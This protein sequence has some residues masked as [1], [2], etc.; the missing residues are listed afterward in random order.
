MKKLM[1]LS[2]CSMVLFSSCVAKKEFL[3]LEAKQQETQDLLNTA[4]VKLNSCLSDAAAANARVE[5]MKEQLSDMRRSNEA[6]I[7]NSQ[8]MTEL[9]SQGAKNIEASLESLRESTLKIRYDRAHQSR[10][11]KHRG[12]FRE[13]KREYPKNNAVTRCTNT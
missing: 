1:L 6:L 7:K 4:T 8:D 2:I 9:T 12:F 11:K 13:S 5:T 10:C 3:A